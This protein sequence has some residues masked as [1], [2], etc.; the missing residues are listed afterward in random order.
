MPTEQ[1]DDELGVE[2]PTYL[3]PT[4]DLFIA[5]YQKGN[6][7]I[8]GILLRLAVLVD[9]EARADERKKVLDEKWDTVFTD[10]QKDTLI[11]HE[12]L[13]LIARLRVIRSSMCLK[14]REILLKEINKLNE[15]I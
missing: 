15:E 14:D 10:V 12:R 9:K 2:I 7:D 6:T 1:D 8:N 13:N 5:E 3:K 11:K 4:L